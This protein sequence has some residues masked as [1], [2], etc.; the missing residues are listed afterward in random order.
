MG[1]KTSVQLNRLT[2][3]EEAHRLLKYVEDAYA[4]I[5]NILAKDVE[6]T[7]PSYSPQAG[8]NA[9][10]LQSSSS[11]EER[12][13]NMRLLQ[14]QFSNGDSSAGGGEPERLMN[15]R[16]DIFI[17]HPPTAI[18]V[19]AVTPVSLV[20]AMNAQ[21]RAAGDNN[22][23]L[24][25]LAANVATGK[26]ELAERIVVVEDVEEEKLSVG[27]V[28]VIIACSV[29]GVALFAV[30]CIA[31]LS[32]PT[33]EEQMDAALDAEERAG[34]EAAREQRASRKYVAAGGSSRY[35]YKVSPRGESPDRGSA[36]GDGDSYQYPQQTPS[37]SDDWA[38][39]KQNA[40]GVENGLVLEDFSDATSGMFDPPTSNLSD[41]PLAGTIF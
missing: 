5:L 6:V 31:A 30:L 25:L 9:R 4:T 20:S 11:E 23:F 24:P 7:G 37:Q 10:L 39:P 29:V 21:I 36:H 26:W 40:F 17:A 32:K 28:I 14:L 15:A 8:Q 38:K 19:S 41:D 33:A 34:M 3:V 1:S 22:I 18:D 27:M 16:Y 13:N 35:S 2:N 12:Q